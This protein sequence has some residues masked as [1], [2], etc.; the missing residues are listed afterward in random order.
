MKAFNN[1]P[2]EQAWVYDNSNIWIVRRRPQSSGD[3]RHDDSERRT[4]NVPYVVRQLA[5]RPRFRQFYWLIANDDVR[6]KVDQTTSFYPTFVALKVMVA[7]TGEV[8]GAG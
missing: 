1:L 2:K 5:V 8:V 7:P 4:W 3:P 6:Y